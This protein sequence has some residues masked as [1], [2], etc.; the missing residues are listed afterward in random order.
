MEKIGLG[1]QEIPSL[2]DYALASWGPTGTLRHT[3]IP[4]FSHWLVM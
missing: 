2:R 1:F 3:D 4:Q